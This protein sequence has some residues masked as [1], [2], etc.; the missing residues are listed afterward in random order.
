MAHTANSARREL[1]NNTPDRNVRAG[2]I[3]TA[4]GDQHVVPPNDRQ[5]LAAQ[6]V[7]TIS[8]AGT[9]FAFAQFRAVLNQLNTALTD[10]DEPVEIDLTG[11]EF[12]AQPAWCPY[13]RSSP[14]TPNATASSASCTRRA[15]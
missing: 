9:T 1:K 8:A 10:S 2:V 12:F 11:P 7:K 15:R 13:S 5:H 14:T 4:T 6:R 3:T